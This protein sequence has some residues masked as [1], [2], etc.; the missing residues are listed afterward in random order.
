MIGTTPKGN[1]NNNSVSVQNTRVA[2]YI[3]GGYNLGSEGDASENKV[4]LKNVTLY[5]GD[6]IAGHFVVGGLVGEGAQE[7]Q[8]TIRLLS[9]IVVL[10]ESF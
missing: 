5:D 3:A 7:M 9:K 6:A 2:T 8:L 1:T 4:Y 10:K